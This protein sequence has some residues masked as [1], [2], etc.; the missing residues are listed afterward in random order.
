MP[1]FA[2]QNSP[3][4]NGRA[5]RVCAAGLCRPVSPFCWSMAA[6]HGLNLSDAPPG[7]AGCV[8]SC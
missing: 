3:M 4:R 6:R 2:Y 5:H 1:P 8:V 7:E